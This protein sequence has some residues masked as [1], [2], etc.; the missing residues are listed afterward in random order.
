M[1]PPHELLEQALPTDVEV[2]AEHTSAHATTPTTGAVPPIPPEEQTYTAEDGS[3]RTVTLPE[4]HIFSITDWS[5]PKPE[6]DLP[7]DEGAEA[8]G[9]P[10]WTGEE[11]LDYY[12]TKT[13]RRLI[14]TYREFPSPIIDLVFADDTPN[15]I[16][17]ASLDSAVPESGLEAG[18]DREQSFYESDI[19]RPR[20]PDLAVRHGNVHEV[21]LTADAFGRP[22]HLDVWQHKMNEVGPTTEPTDWYSPISTE[23]PQ[24]IQPWRESWRAQGE[25]AY[26]AENFN[27][28]TG[29]SDAYS[30]H[31]P[32]PMARYA[33]E[34]WGAGRK[35]KTVESNES[36]VSLPT[37][38][39]QLLLPSD[40]DQH[41]RGRSGEKGGTEHETDLVYDPWRDP[42]FHFRTRN[43]YAYDRGWHTRTRSTGDEHQYTSRTY[44][45]LYGYDPLGYRVVG[46]ERGSDTTFRVV[47]I[48]GDSY[49]DIEA[50]I[51][52]KQAGTTL[53]DVAQA[54]ADAMM[55]DSV[56]SS[57]YTASAEGN[58]VVI[59]SVA[60]PEEGDLVVEETPHDSLSWEIE[61]IDT[62]QEDLV[63]LRFTEQDEIEANTW[64][65]EMI[66]GWPVVPYESDEV[67]EIALGQSSLPDQRYSKALL[68]ADMRRPGT[69]DI[70]YDE[71]TPEGVM[72]RVPSVTTD[73][74]AYD[75]LAVDGIAKSTDNGVAGL[76][77]PC[78][79]YST[80]ELRDAS[81]RPRIEVEVE[82]DIAGL[83]FQVGDGARA[84][85]WQGKDWLVI[86][87]E[88]KADRPVATLTLERYARGERVLYS[89]SEPSLAAPRDARLRKVLVHELRDGDSA[90]GSLLTTNRPAEI[91]VLQW[92]TPRY[93]DQAAV[94][95]YEIQRINTEWTEPDHYVRQAV[96]TGTS[97]YIKTR[98]TT[99]EFKSD[100]RLRAVGFPD[101]NGEVQTSSWVYP[102]KEDT[103]I[104]RSTNIT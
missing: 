55:A 95:Y 39:C 11:L 104:L 62:A 45:G 88:R 20:L 85:T 72:S 69:T 17:T 84:V 50:T 8:T 92:D 74:E 78:W 29:Y 67:Y 19:Q 71:R 103:R 63:I 56:F 5:G 26:P 61:Y 102:T 65:I 52:P 91:L 22:E 30:A 32:P 2:S 54:V 76:V 90:G 86:Q 51:K 60:A 6:D 41:A 18:A 80:W 31:T 47:E 44:P 14:A 96:T 40:T 36:S 23:H 82:V 68:W 21:S 64:E 58:E 99:A 73:Q 10:A 57:S 25:F 93:D 43:G 98:S 7:D 89:R 87:M 94:W 1:W 97:Y 48:K 59:G 28:T 66:Y 77:N 35:T 49:Y 46:A 70:P 101:E 12:L 13:G 33:A 79:A 75:Y 24:D 15:L 38:I 9:V 42:A 81:T 4:V 83:D 3:R 53:S 16:S 100:F 34:R 37:R 27:V